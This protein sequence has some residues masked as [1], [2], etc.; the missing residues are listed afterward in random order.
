MTKKTFYQ[1]CLLLVCIHSSWSQTVLSE[2][3][4]SPTATTT[5]ASNVF[6]NNTSLSYSNGG[7]SNSADVRTTNA[8]TGYSGASSGGNI[9]FSSI[10]GAY[11]F[12]IEGINASSHTSLSLQFGYR[13]ES[14]SGHALFSVDYWNG[15]TWVVLANSETDLFNESASASAKWYLSKVLTL[16]VEAQ[17]NGLKIRFVKTGTTAIRIDDVLLTANETPIDT[18]SS[19]SDIVFNPSSSTSSNTNINY[20]NYQADVITSTTNSVGVMGFYLRDSGTLSN[21]HDSLATELTEITFNVTNS[22]NIRSARLFVGNSPRGVSVPVNGASTIAFT[23]LT[24]IIAADDDQLAINLRVTFNEVVT[25]NEQVQFTVS[26]ATANPTGSQ[27]STANAGGASSSISGNINRIEVTASKLEFSQQPSDLYVGLIMNPAPI[28][29]VLDVNG[30]I[31]LDYV[32]SVTLTSSGTLT[33]SQIVNATAGEAVFNDVSHSVFGTN[34]VLTAIS[35]GLVSTNSNS[36]VVINSP[37]GD[38]IN[39]FPNEVVEL[40]FDGL[41]CQIN[42]CNLVVNG[43][44]EEYTALPTGTNQI[45]KACGWIA[46]YGTV[47]YYNAGSTFS[48]VSVPCSSLGGQSSNNNEGSGYAGIMFT[49]F[50]SNPSEV[51]VSKLKTPLL[52]NTDYKLSLDVSL[53][54]G[55]SSFSKAIQV[56]L[57]PT[58]NSIIPNTPFSINN[59][60]MLFSNSTTST[61]TNGWETL[62]FNFTTGAGGEEFIYIGGFQDVISQPNIPGTN[63]SCTYGNYNIPI[64]IPMQFAYY[65]IDNVSLIPVINLNLPDTICNTAGLSN[66]S[67]FLSNTPTNGIFTGAGVVENAGNYS[68]DATI[69]GIGTHTISYTYTNSGCSPITISCNITVVTDGIVAEFEFLNSLVLCENSTPPA[70]PTTSDNGITGTW[71][72]STISTTASENYTFTADSGQCSTSISFPV[73][74]LPNETFVTNNDSFYMYPESSLTTASVLE[75][76]TF[77]GNAINTV[78]AVVD[79]NITLENPLPTFTSGGIVINQDGTFTISPDTPHGN[80]VFNY[81]IT[82]SCGVSNSSTVTISFNNYVEDLGKIHFQYCFQNDG[83]TIYNS[84]TSNLGHTSLYDLVTVLG[85]PASSSNASIQLITSPSVPITINANGTFTITSAIHTAVFPSMDYRFTY[86]VCSNGFC[87]GDILCH[88]VIKNSVEA[89]PDAITFYNDG[90]SIVTSINVLADDIKWNCFN[91]TP[92]SIGDVVITQISPDNGAYW[93]NIGTG[94]ININEGAPVGIYIIEYRICDIAFP[95]NCSTSQAWIHQC[96]PLEPTLPGN[97]CYYGRI[98]NQ[99]EFDLNTLT[100]A[101]NPSNGVFELIFENETPENLTYEVYDMVGKKLFEDYLKEGGKSSFLTLENY[102]QG[103]YLLRVKMGNT[104]V[105]KKLIKN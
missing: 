102:P 14:S 59:S 19:S 62:T 95:N 99:I 61:V 16:P 101:P 50:E 42:S 41:N 38:F 63:P 87:S 52:P 92:I 79:Y 84:V 26:S 2:N 82:T 64:Y 3:M 1:I 8:S 66:L 49:Y 91:P 76:D 69:A 30:N 12:S 17:I 28:V 5:I 10:S 71:N 4:G 73:Y 54:E 36:F 39:N 20:L 27:F 57:S 98:S 33:N 23:G 37:I 24:N 34:I 35:S 58:A 105:N 29:R 103:I 15:S 21:D 53:A 74:I 60:E 83:N 81:T 72:P 85:E 46:A 40:N 96:N 77:N 18:P 86:R 88:V 43:D 104:I 89:Q 25:D 97:P 7:Q 65:Y 93:I 31:D 51:I 70:L 6:E 55:M 75:N 68:F 22:V 47:E 80:Y 78:P 11:G 67:S 90:S 32:E 45:E 44:F 100:V 9:F 56:Y 94:V 48:N 13:K